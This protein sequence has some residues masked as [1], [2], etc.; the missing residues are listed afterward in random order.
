MARVNLR[1]LLQTQ[2]SPPIAG[3]HMRDRVV[4]CRFESGPRSSMRGSST[5]ERDDINVIPLAKVRRATPAALQ[6]P[7]DGHSSGP[8][9]C[10]QADPQSLSLPTAHP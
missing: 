3:L 8:A 10:P 4:E 5:E 7:G 2:H 6:G 9:P 1:F